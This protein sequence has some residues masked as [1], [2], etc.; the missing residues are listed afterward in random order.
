LRRHAKASLARSHKPTGRGALGLTCI[1]L[2]ALAAIAGPVSVAAAE[3]PSGRA[4][5]LVSPID[6]PSGTNAGLLSSLVPVP[7]IASDN[8]DRFLYGAAAPMGDAWSGQS[9][10]MIFG[11]RTA[12]GWKAN[13][14]TVS[15]D[16]GNTALQI[17]AT[18]AQWGWLTPD[19]SSYTFWAQ[20]FGAIPVAPAQNLPGVFRATDDGSAPEWLTRPI[21]G[22]APEP[23]SGTPN[24]V[25]RIAFANRDASV[26]ALESMAPLSTEAPSA[27]TPAVYASRAGKLEL[28]SRLPGGTAA[29]EGSSIA[30]N[31]E[32]P[33]PTVTYCSA[34]AG[35]GRFV[36][37]NVGG[38]SAA[39]SLY[40]RDLQQ[41]VTRQ[42]SGPAV[43]L[44]EATLVAA[45]RDGA[46]A[47]FARA[48]V[49]YEANL[50]DG[51]STVRTAITGSP[52]G[53]SP[54]GRRMLFLEPPTGGTDWT[55]RYWD[56]SSPGTSVAVGSLGA[57][58]TP[59]LSVQ[60]QVRA[61]VYRSLD[62][63]RTWVFSA[64]GSPDPVRPNVSPN[65][66]QLYRW[67]VGD[68]APTCL[69]CGPVDGV[70]RTSGVNLTVQ[71]VVGTEVMTDPAATAFEASTDFGF[72]AR[73]LAQ[74]GHSISDD[75]SL[76]LFDSPDKLVAED[77]NGI[78][79]VYLWDGNRAAGNQLQL[80]T[81]GKGNT[82]SYA[83]DLDPTGANAFFS[84]REGLVPADRNG[85][86]NVY[87][88]RIGGGFPESGESCAG[89]A[90]RPPAVPPLPAAISSGTLGDGNVRPNRGPAKPSIELVRARATGGSV[91]KLRVHV[92]GSGRLAVSGP[93]VRSSG[94]KVSRAGTYPVTVRPNA[95]A[96]GRLAKK[97]SLKVR[98]RVS[99]RAKGGRSV[100]KTVTVTFEAKA[101][102]RKGR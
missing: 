98:A 16:H 63:G 50:E 74:P 59:A 30:C 23:V 80:V 99:Y 31:H 28:V 4:Y 47:Y 83:L 37:F 62:E 43:S 95:R 88:A 13:T 1:C 64:A 20:N 84:T 101:A 61:R 93:L 45:P 11:R 53:L 10:A 34:L 51:T 76:I 44:P 41:Q 79:D 5:E 35:S 8:G 36:L 65:T 12:T 52:I 92:S 58:I 94:R 49:T 25:K 40:V 7:G 72:S 19:G 97:K 85:N 14:A 69:S 100:S 54:D 81:S 6:D 26:V 71:Q 48:G 102:A 33:A 66:Q 75:G 87:D 57:S 18:E 29:T 39:R 73:K 3:P 82:P 38:T 17:I 56:E 89:E 24:T 46:R 32:F 70:A 68:I 42:L 77:T 22:I 27:P 60:A 55:L 91:A 90:C 21:D 96:K 67:T 86:Y 78:R 15:V 9:N 2:L